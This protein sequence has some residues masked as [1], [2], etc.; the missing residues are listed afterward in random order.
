MQEAVRDCQRET[1]NFCDEKQAM[2]VCFYKV[3]LAEN[4]KISLCT[5]TRRVKILTNLE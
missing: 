5:Q 2:H 4:F 3:F 1:G